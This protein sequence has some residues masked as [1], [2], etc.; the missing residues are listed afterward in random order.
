MATD[1]GRENLTK[2]CGRVEYLSTNGGTE[3]VIAI[4]M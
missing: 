2:A 1:M 3:I 4:N